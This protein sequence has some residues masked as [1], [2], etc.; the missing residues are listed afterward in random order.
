[1]LASTLGELWSCK[2]AKDS[3]TVTKRV[4]GVGVGDTERQ[5]RKGQVNIGHARDRGDNGKE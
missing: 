4:K 5:G 1:M 2:G 3:G